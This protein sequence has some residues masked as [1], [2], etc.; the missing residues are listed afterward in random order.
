MRMTQPEGC[1]LR[2][3]RSL[4]PQARNACAT[5]Y[6]QATGQ[7]RLRY[8]AI[9]PFQQPDEELDTKTAELGRGRFH[10]RQRWHGQLGEAR[11]YADLNQRKIVRDAPAALG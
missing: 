6:H 9:R 7:Q 11:G 8:I 2:S 10:G 5:P 3:P 1:I 4:R